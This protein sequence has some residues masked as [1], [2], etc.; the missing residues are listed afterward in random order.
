MAVAVFGIDE[1]AAVGDALARF[2][3]RA[4]VTAS[5]KM[6]SRVSPGGS[7]TLPPSMFHTAPE[8]NKAP[9]PTPTSVTP[10]AISRLIEL[11]RRIA[12]PNPARGAPD[13]GVAHL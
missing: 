13:A 1:A 6:M 7:P 12:E 10:R 3:M 5:L 9:E 11:S 4:T 2:H 8:P